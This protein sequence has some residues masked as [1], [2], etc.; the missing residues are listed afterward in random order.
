MIR[1]NHVHAIT[2]AGSGNSGD[3]AGIVVR[4]A[5]G[6]KVWNNT[7]QVTGGPCIVMTWSDDAHPSD[8]QVINNALSG[9]GNA[10]LWAKDVAI[11]NLKIDYNGYDRA[12]GARLQVGSR[13]Y[14]LAT[15]RV[16]T[17]FDMHS[18]ETNGAVGSTGLLVAGAGLIDGGMNLGLPF[19][20]AA[21]DI[22][23]YEVGCGQ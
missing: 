2:L 18:L 14:S 20:G 11:P 9:C 12:G 16:A 21:A 10:E 7:V 22:G 3:G 4:E 6:V 5:T 19:C 17:G 23:A 15:W 13:V 8:V 1:N